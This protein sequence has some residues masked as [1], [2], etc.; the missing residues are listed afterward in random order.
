MEFRVKLDDLQDFKKTLKRLPRD[1][2]K[3]IGKAMRKSI[4]LIEK[5]AKPIT[6][7]DT[8][9]LR[10]S[11]RPDFIRTYEGAIAP[12]TDYAIYVHEGTR[13]MKGR[14]FMTKA[15]QQS[16]ESIEGLFKS[17]IDKAIM[18]SIYGI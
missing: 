4:L 17:A 3:E 6:P 13:Y 14:P 5:K 18:K 10:A 12:H 1:L 7:V 16:S 11:I 9:R 8:G 15:L 2:N